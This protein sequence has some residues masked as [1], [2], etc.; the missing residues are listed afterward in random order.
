MDEALSNS[1]TN[2]PVAS[3]AQDM[4][5]QIKLLSRDISKKE[6]ELEDAER[7]MHSM[8]ED[9]HISLQ[10]ELIASLREEV[11]SLDLKYDEMVR[12]REKI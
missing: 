1:P 3:R 9:V 5:V 8:D 2:W 12:E 11:R 10:K 7:D 6:D 4:D